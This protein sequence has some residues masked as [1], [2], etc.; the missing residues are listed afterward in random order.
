MARSASVNYRDP[1]AKPLHSGEPVVSKQGVIQQINSGGDFLPVEGLLNKL[2]PILRLTVIA[3]QPNPYP[4]SQ[5]HKKLLIM[6]SGA[7]ADVSDARFS[8]K[9][10]CVQLI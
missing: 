3:P 4:P 7:L 9:S 1:E 2:I 5:K 10:A 6:K 8:L